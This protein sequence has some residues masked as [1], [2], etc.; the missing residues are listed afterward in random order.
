MGLLGVDTIGLRM[1]AA[2][3]QSWAAEIEATNQPGSAGLSCQATSTAV[4]AVHADVVAAAQSLAGRMQS[5]AA[6]LNAASAQYT[7]N[8][9]DSAAQLNAATIEL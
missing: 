1:L 5:T 7:L 3:C 9:E 8:D 2:H 4:A 6:K